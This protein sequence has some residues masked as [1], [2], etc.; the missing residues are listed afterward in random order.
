LK[1]ALNDILALGEVWRA[2]EA[3]L[4][5]LAPPALAARLQILA[6]DLPGHGTTGP[7]LAA[8]ARGGLPAADWEAVG[9][10]ILAAVEAAAAAA[11]SGGRSCSRAKGLIS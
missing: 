1:S 6:P 4:R 8:G 3:E 2:V 7:P 10:H 11:A 9:A 5:Q